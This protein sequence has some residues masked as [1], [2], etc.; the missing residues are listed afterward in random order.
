MKTKILSFIPVVVCSTFTALSSAFA[1]GTAFTYQGVLAASNAPVNGTYDLTFALWDSLAGGNQVGNSITNPGFLV[2]SGQLTATLDFGANF[3]GTPLWLEIGVR[4]NG[5]TSFSTLSPRQPLTPT[6]YAIYAESATGLANGVA[7]GSGTGNMISPNGGPDS[8]IGG[9]NANNILNGSMNSAIAGGQGNLVQPGAA[10]S[11]IGGGMNNMSASIMATVGGG[12]QNNASGANATV[13]GGFQN[14]AS[15]SYATVG[16]GGQNSASGDYSTVAGGGGN[17]NSAMGNSSYIGGGSGNVV[18]A[19][20]DFATIGG[21]SG[22]HASFFYATVGGGLNNYATGQYA[23]IGGGEQNVANRTEATVA[24]GSF[25]TAS[26]QDATVAGGY[27]NVIQVNS[28][29]S[30]IGGGSNNTIQASVNFNHPTESIG[31][32]IAGGLHNTIQTDGAM[33]TIG[34]GYQNQISANAAFLGGGEQNSIEADASVVCGGENNDA[35]GAVGFIGGGE[36]NTLTGDHSMAPGGQGNTAA[37]YSFAAGYYAQ[38]NNNGCFIWADS[39]PAFSIPFNSVRD[40][41]FAA[42]ATG[43]VRFV[44]A[45]DGSGNPTAGVSVGSGQTSWTSICDRNAKKNFAPVNGE[46]IL[47]KLAAVAVKKWNYK[48]E[49]DSDVPHIGPMAQDFKAAFYPGRDDKN[50]ST[51]EFDGVELAAI[52][53]L[54][55]KVENQLKSK[56]AEIQELKARLA[57]LEQLLETR[58]GAHQ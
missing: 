16:G 42:R 50:I 55:E 52:Q 49:K 10:F 30:F 37:Q 40:F 44:T 51:L 54:N 22:N 56:E 4:T 19:L 1:Q 23:T 46:E 35:Q 6:P 14:T 29:T 21:G 20:S 7:L 43:G 38:A 12:G 45:V 5:A 11:F 41:E 8:F 2:M 31:A 27:D 28:T 58:K 25:N 48:W 13:A 47:A 36:N 18:N 26:G 33:S 57:T 17:G 32:A 39:G 3:S 9:G 24:G 15:G 53:G 34:G